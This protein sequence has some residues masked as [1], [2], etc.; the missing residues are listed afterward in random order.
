MFMLPRSELGIRHHAADLRKEERLMFQ[1]DIRS[2]KSIYEQIIDNIRELIM[3]DILPE[4]TKLPSVRELSRQLTVNPNTVQKAFKELEREG[5]IF[6]V[7][8]RGTF[9]ASKSNIRIDEK[10]V[11]EALLSVV[12]AYRTLLY[13]GLSPETARDKIL[14]VIEDFNERERR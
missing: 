6:T 5:Y 12:E 8:G 11:R 3:T 13:T 2:G 14:H 4:D 10:T 1:L 7:S 9:V